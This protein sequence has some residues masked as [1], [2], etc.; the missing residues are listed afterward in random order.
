MRKVFC[1]TNL[2]II[3]SVAL[4]SCATPASI[5]TLRPS[6]GPE[7]ATPQLARFMRERVNVPFAFAMMESETNRPIRMHKAAG[8]MREAARHLVHW[9]TP[10][11][12]SPQGREVFYAYA[13]SLERHIGRLE[14]A[15]AARETDAI[16]NSLERIRQTCND[17]HH[18][19]RPASQLSRDVMF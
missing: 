19:F 16:A 4:A 18:F 11:S 5:T 9:S 15:S 13:Q 2:T 1:S 10:P 12:A 7:S 17:C 3:T 14:F 6:G 8:L